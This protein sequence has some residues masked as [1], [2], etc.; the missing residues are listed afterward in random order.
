MAAQDKP[1]QKKH[2]LTPE[3]TQREQA[4]RERRIAEILVRVKRRLR[5]EK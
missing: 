4:E 3:L 5:F 1:I 2:Q